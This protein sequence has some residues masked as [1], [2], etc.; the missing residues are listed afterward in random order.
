MRE[1]FSVF[2]RKKVTFT[3]NITFEDA[4]DWGE[5]WTPNLAQMFLIEFYGMLQ[6]FRVT[7]FTIFELLRENQLV[8][9]GKITSPPPT[10]THTP[11]LGLRIRLFFQKKLQQI[12][13]ISSSRKILTNWKMSPIL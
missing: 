3:E 5:L 9:G 6:N 4:G 13:I 12:L 1:L 11:R 2:V 7:V 10:H 8:V